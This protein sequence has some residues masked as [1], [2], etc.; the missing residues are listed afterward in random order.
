MA[1]KTLAVVLT[2]QAAVGVLSAQDRAW[3]F[4]VGSRVTL[5]TS[6]KLFYLPGDSSEI[7]RSRYEGLKSILGGALEVRARP[8]QSSIF[9]SLSA[10]YQRKTTSQPR[11]T[12]FTSPA[13]ILPTEDGYWMIPIEATVNVDVPLGAERFWLTMGAGAGVY[14]AQRILEVAGVM[15]NPADVK[16]AYGLH[17]RT[18]ADYRITEWLTVTFELRFRNPQI[19]TFNRFHQASTTFDGALVEFPQEEIEG[20]IEA[21][22]MTV[23]LGIV[24]DL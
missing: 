19:T 12:G 10:E 17:V 7:V 9:F 21:D 5:T 11:L 22:G 15:A 8:P 16:P 2:L 20:R 23:G 24:V 3:V 6:S 1:L 14:Y 13:S 18:S 4:N